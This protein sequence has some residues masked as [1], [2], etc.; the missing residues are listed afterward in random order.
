[1]G[2]STKYNDRREDTK[3]YSIDK[4]KVIIYGI[5]NQII[6]LMLDKLSAIIDKDLMYYESKGVSKCYR[7]FTYK[8]IY[9]G[10]DNNWNKIYSKNTKNVVIE[11]NPNKVKLDKFPIDLKIL[12]D[13]LNKVEVMCFDVAIDIPIA[14]EN[15]IILKQ[16]ELQRM[17]I[18]SHSSAETYYIGKFNENG[19]CRIYD[20]AK[21]SKL[22]Y[23]LTRIEIHLKNVGLYG[24]YESIKKLK[25]PHVL[26]FNESNLNDISN[27]NRVLVQACYLIPH[28]LSMLEKR[29]RK[30]IKDLIKNN[31]KQI[32]I[33]IEKIM[34]TCLN[35]K[36]I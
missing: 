25:L 15:L 3:M 21:E 27:T 32:D 16:H 13:D 1:M 12:F 20:K 29:K 7:N 22:D 36:F 9:L 34:E 30:Q 31:L 17:N 23:D 24:Y 4:V 11:W 35:F 2:V 26:I 33:S 19:F 10:F 28:L 18:L 8:G 6:Q 14:I 5:K